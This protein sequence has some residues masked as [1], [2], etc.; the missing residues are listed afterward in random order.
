MVI[1]K[2]IILIIILYIINYYISKNENNRDEKKLTYVENDKNKDRIK[3]YKDISNLLFIP[4]IK[5]YN[6]QAYNEIIEYFDAFL[7][8]YEII[9]IDPSKASY[10]YTNMIDDKKY[11]LNSLLSTSIKIPYEFNLSD[12]IDDFTEILD[13][14]LSEVYDIYN[15]YI[16]INGYD[17]TT[18]VI[19]LN[20][21]DAYNIDDNIV[22]PGNKL[23]FNRI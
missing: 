19:Y 10:L 23:L 3:N 11:I 14:Y 9:K 6:T 13:K 18:N 4:E 12:V 22:E 1:I 15:D 21:P 5:Y 7:E 8:C 2:I 20:H 17:Y 16:N